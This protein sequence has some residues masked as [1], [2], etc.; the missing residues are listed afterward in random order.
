MRKQHFPSVRLCRRGT[1][2]GPP[3]TWTLWGL[4]LGLTAA[5]RLPPQPCFAA[6][7]MWAFDPA[8]Y[9]VINRVQAADL[10]VTYKVDLSGLLFSRTQHYTVEEVAGLEEAVHA[11]FDLWNAAIRPIGLQFVR[12]GAADA[13]ELPVFAFNY[14]A[15]LPDDIF[16]DTVAGALNLPT[17]NV[18][19]VLPIVLDNSERF[20]DL[21]HLPPLLEPTLQQPYVKYVADG[22]VDAFSVMVHEIGHELGLGHPVEVLDGGRNY[23]FLELTTVQVDPGCLAPS[24]RIS[25]EDTSRRRPMLRTEIDS[26]MAP[27][28]V[29]AVVLEIAPDDLA[30]TAFI[31]RRLNPAGADEVLRRARARFQ[32][33]NPFRFANVIGEVEEASSERPN[34]DRFEWAMPIEPGQIIVGSLAAARRDPQTKDQDCFRLEVAPELAGLTFYL[35]IDAGGGLQGVSWADSILEV[36]DGDHVFLAASDDSDSVD[37]GSISVVDPFLV[38]TPI[39]AGTY[40]VR[41]HSKPPLPEEGSVGDYV[42][43]VGVG[44]VPEPS[45]AAEPEPDPTVGDCRFEAVKPVLV[46]SACGVLGLGTTLLWGM[47]SGLGVGL[48]RLRR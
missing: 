34:N 45:G 9:P 11:A 43:K 26:V 42:L 30:F 12:V 7:H 20:V 19:S 5:A 36:F 33:T 47:L 23:N 48:R 37:P 25:G 17:G 8:E 44:A 27:I 38:W 4:V 22:G 29:G 3:L 35:D 10:G 14:S 2:A 18:L 39:S 31:L 40:Y 16:G 6:G 1:T 32:Q 21:R 41:L 15:Y 13:A 24:E 46:P 28:R